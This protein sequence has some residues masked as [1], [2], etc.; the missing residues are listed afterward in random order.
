L[1][2]FKQPV[3]TAEPIEHAWR[4]YNQG[5]SITAAQCCKRLLNQFPDYVQA[6]YLL[7]L[8]QWHSGETNSAICSLKQAIRLQPNHPLPYNTLGVLFMEIEDYQ[9]A[10]SY[11][12]QALKLSPEY[13]DARCNL[14]LALFHLDQPAQALRCLEQ[15]TEAKPDHAAAWAN[16]G[17]VHLTLGNL[18]PAAAAYEKALAAKP[19]K[20]HWQ[21][22]LGA[23]YLGMDCFAQAARCFQRALDADP[24]N[25]NYYVNLGIAFRAMG[26]WPGSIEIL[27]RA[28]IRTPNH[29]PALA[30]LVLAY[31]Q[32]CQWSK[33]ASLYGRLDSLT[34]TAI[35]KGALPDEQP[36]LNIRRCA[37][38]D[39]N[40]AVASAWSRH[41]EGRALKICKRFSHQRPA[42]S[43]GRI[44]I[45]YLSYD[46]RDHPVAHQLAPLFGLHDRSRFCVK[47]FSMGP[48][49]GS[50]FRHEIQRTSDVFVDINRYGLRK[51]AAAI[52]EHQV[53]ILVDLAG[54]THHNRMEIP[55][56][57]PAPLQVS[58][59]GFL[60]ST[61]A[62]FIDY[63][64]ADAVV[65]P[66][67]HAKFYSEKIIRLPHCYQM[68]HRL[69]IKETPSPCRRQ[70]H[71]PEDGFVYCS[72]NQIYK[73]EPDLYDTWMRILQ[74][75]PKSV[76]W[77]LGDRSSAVAQL[78]HAAKQNQIDQ[79]RIIFAD[80]LLLDQHLH[81]LQA[82]DLALDTI[83]YNG[84]ATTANC[85]CAAVPVLSV[86]GRHWVSRM[87]ASHL[88][89]AG[90]PELVTPD[91]KSYE[92]TAVGLARNPNCLKMLRDRLQTAHTASGLF[93][94]REFVRNLETAFGKIWK[95]YLHGQAPI[96]IQVQPE[97]HSMENLQVNAS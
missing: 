95:R 47:T 70:L 57:R 63:I 52:F 86:L 40:L 14:G 30:N 55:A 80:K 24:N 42:H 9:Q 19:C 64:I 51:A 13:L 11:F 32:T 85:L 12:Q 54:H 22:N 76:L 38:P 41:I 37:D 83:T 87:S 53:D 18:L 92:Q 67:D 81:R 59:L 27:E 65:V 56:L 73:I 90:L 43:R 23:A 88:Y 96:D 94:P 93:R 2:S 29:G 48:D 17:M 15:V 77:L 25:L 75:V 66:Y 36:L 68:N 50:A 78:R 21:G 58:Y 10:C 82:A 8:A 89:C 34:R 33:L 5:E 91:L 60:S 26:N 28:L 45:G 1:I 4:L 74:Q 39:I 49:D 16:L 35:D 20:P 62:D 71:L 46:F 44:T 6:W 3:N 7:G 31:Q 84:G 61:G 97:S 69:L 79:K 72:F